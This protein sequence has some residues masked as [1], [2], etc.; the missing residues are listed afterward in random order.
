MLWECACCVT[1]Q[2][3]V[4]DDVAKAAM[5]RNT[6]SENVKKLNNAALSDTFFTFSRLVG[7]LRVD[8]WQ[9]GQSLNLRYNKA[10]Y[11]QTMH[12]TATNLLAL[13]ADGSLEKAANRLDLSSGVR[14]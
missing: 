12:K 5:A 13:M 3:Q 14:S 7:L 1:I 9:E 2:V 11:N 6:A 10:A 8:A 4:C